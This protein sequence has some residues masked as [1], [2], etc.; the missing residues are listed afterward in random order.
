METRSNLIYRDPIEGLDFSRI[1]AGVMLWGAWGKNLNA[2]DMC[3]LIEQCVDLG[4]TTFDHADIY[5]HYTTEKTFGEALA[6]QPSLKDKIEIITK[7]GIR[8][9]TPNRP[10]NKI[11]SYDTSKAHIIASVERSLA[12][13][14][15]D[16]LNLFLIHRPD[17]LLDLNELIEAIGELLESGKVMHFG[18]SNFKPSKVDTLDAYFFDLELATN[19]VQASLLH[20]DPFEDGT[21]DQ[22]MTMGISPMA[23]SPLGGGKLFMAQSDDPQ[24]NRIR[25][26]AQTLMEKY[27]ASMDQ[28]ALAW[29]MR[30]PAQILPV[31]GTGRFDRIASAWKALEIDMEREDWFALLEASK[32]KEVD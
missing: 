15:V 13:L 25:P 21:F 3:G 32:G 26:V 8:L 20:L 30:H 4:V 7:C 31:I 22:C 23:W 6:L 12:D 9:V 11:K 16:R 10:A 19:Q 17:P 2:Q 29:L 24:V 18:V 28:I 27:G 1:V 5:G 14:G